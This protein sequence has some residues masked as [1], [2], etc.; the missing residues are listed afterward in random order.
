V[1]ADAPLD[2]SS[3]IKAFNHKLG[4]CGVTFFARRQREK[5]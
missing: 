4:E 3:S 1:L 5:N 2:A